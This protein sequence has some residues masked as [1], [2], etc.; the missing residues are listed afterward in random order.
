[1]EMGESIKNVGA[2]TLFVGDP[3]R[4]KAFYERV[5]EAAP[6]YEDENSVAF[7]FDNGKLDE[8]VS[9]TVPANARSIAV[10]ERLEMTHAGEF[11]HPLLPA[12][13]PLSRHVLYRLGPRP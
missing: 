6:V 12:G 3:Q 9:F 5:F 2:I 11:S 4:S 10:M 13:H 1:M 8:I 7:G